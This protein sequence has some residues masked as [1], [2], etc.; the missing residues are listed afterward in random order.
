MFRIFLPI[1]F[2]VVYGQKKLHFKE[3]TVKIFDH[4]KVQLNEYET[5]PYF[6]QIYQS[7]TTVCLII[8]L[9]GKSCEPEIVFLIC[10]LASQF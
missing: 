8:H 1:K 9:F 2:S 5:D 6:L 7:N 4:E 3:T 10:T